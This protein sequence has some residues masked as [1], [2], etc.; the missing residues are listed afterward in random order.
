MQ[1]Y[2]QTFAANTTWQLNVPG[3]YFVTLACTLSLNVRFYLGGK[4]L[5]LGD[6][7]GLLAGLEVG[8]L[9]GLNDPIAFDR[10]EIDVQAG[11]TVKVGI[12]N[13]ATRYNRLVGSVDVLSIAQAAILQLIRPELSTGSF[14]LNAAIAAATPDTIFTPAANLNGAILLSA[15][16]ASWGTNPSGFAFIAKGSAPVSNVD[17]EVFLGAGTVA[18]QATA[19]YGDSGILPAPQ[20]IAAGLGLYY[21]TAQAASPCFR[22]ARYRL[23]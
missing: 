17:G 21:I 16:S 19:Q 20:Y 12:G 15:H 9:G 1:T 10:V 18:T 14:K 6:I 4:K 2:N 5:D 13:G 3:K 8:P 7:T 23:L 22:A 11:D